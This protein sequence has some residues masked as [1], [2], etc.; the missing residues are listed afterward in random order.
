[1]LS[2]RE[3]GSVTTLELEFSGADGTLYEGE[4]FAL[5]F[6]LDHTY[7]MEPPSCYF[8][9]DAVHKS[10]E[11]EHVY[12]NGHICLSIL[13]CEWTP[14]LNVMTVAISVLSMLSTAT[15]KSRPP[16]DAE[17]SAACPYGSDPKLV[18][19]TYDDDKV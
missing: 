7:P 13:G 19:F 9:I 3:D 12:S 11:H 10:P 8:V 6:I 2:K 15:V 14:A 17:H 1:M 16:D 4:L 5:R 18:Q